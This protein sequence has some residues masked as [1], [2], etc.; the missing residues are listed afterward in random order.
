MTLIQDASRY[1]TE[2]AGLKVTAREIPPKNLPVFIM[3]QY[4][5][6]TLSLGDE[7]FL[8]VAVKENLSPSALK[9]HQAYFPRHWD[10]SGFV[11]IASRLEGFVRKRLIELKI[12]FVVP[13]VQLY[14]PA[15]GLEF[16]KRQQEKI[17]SAVERFNPATQA[18]VIGILNDLFPPTF[19]PKDLAK[20]LGYTRMS[21]TR[22]V[23]DLQNAGLGKSIKKGLDRFFTPPNKHD[24]W[25][26][27]L[28]LL[29]DPVRLT[30]RLLERDVPKGTKI[31]AGENALARI[32]MLAEPRT[33]T[34]AVGRD[35]GKKL[36]EKAIPNLE[37]AEPGTCAVQ[38]WRYDPALFAKRG[39]VD[40]FSLYLSLKDSTDERVIM[41]LTQA[42]EEHLG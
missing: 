28:S 39:T 10:D 20:K 17:R 26:K 9:K 19:Q 34:Y 12:P 6:Y 21:M 2:I 38:I 1:L 25:E 23:D 16:R 42:I 40:V 36:Q 41:T 13:R 14:W 37:T 18:V 30:L 5:F 3:E 27:A 35:Q 22:A 11:L 24:L 31:L 33:P 4:D 29:I 7:K 32:S 15:L 8:G